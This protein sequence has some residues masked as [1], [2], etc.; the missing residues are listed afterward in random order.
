[1]IRVMTNS[2]AIIKRLVKERNDCLKHAL[3]L[4]INVM[5]FILMGC[6]HGQ[7]NQGEVAS[8]QEYVNKER[9]DKLTYN[10]LN[11][12]FYNI[13]DEKAAKAKAV[14]Q[15]IEYYIVETE[16][17]RRGFTVSEEEIQETINFSI[18]H[19]ERIKEDEEFMTYLEGLDITIEEYYQE[20]TY[21]SIKGKLLENKLVD[22]VTKQADSPEQVVEM[23]NQFKEE[24]ITDYKKKNQ[25]IIIEL[26]ESFNISE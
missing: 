22:E 3:I 25:Q 16:A 9:V 13:T 21:D 19:S 12:E 11:L 2:E 15:L 20:Y 26:K 5:M 17:L 6:G 7:V 8:L 24:S 1:M 4:V 14:D 18:E 10:Y 23:W